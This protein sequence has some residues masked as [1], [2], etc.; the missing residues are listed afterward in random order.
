MNSLERQMEL[1]FVHC[2]GGGGGSTDTSPT[3]E[4]VEQTKI[5]SS[6]WDYY[7]SEYKPTI[8]G[9]GKQIQADAPSRSGQYAGY[10]NAETMRG[11]AGPTSTNPVVNARALSEKARGGAM[12][13]GNA[14]DLAKKENIVD[15]QRLIDIGRGQ[16]TSSAD[17][18]G[19]LAAGSVRSLISDA[20]NDYEEKAS[21]N[22]AIA[23]VAGAG[24]AAYLNYKKK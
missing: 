10:A 17:K 22:E 20:R 6:L 1:G 8:E 19:T 24:A 9:Y 2:F 13:A 12:L 14:E 15:R 18:Y 5:N 16:A 21:S 23:S 7:I 4:M 11:I 3:P